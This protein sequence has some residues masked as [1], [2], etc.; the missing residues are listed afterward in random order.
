MREGQ[1]GEGQMS[2][3]KPEGEK[4]NIA[5]CMIE[6][7][8]QTAEKKILGK[9]QIEALRGIGEGAE[10]MTYARKAQ[11]ILE[12]SDM[13]L[14]LGLRH[15]DIDIFVKRVEGIISELSDTLSDP[16]ISKDSN[17]LIKSLSILRA[18]EKNLTASADMRGHDAG[19]KVAELLT[20]AKYTASFDEQDLP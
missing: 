4:K 5:L 17:V 14:S 7:G 20:L 6:R 15:E 3:A 1:H 11:A 8:R 18:L 19:D 2:G 16:N 13:L 10:V 12:N 9:K